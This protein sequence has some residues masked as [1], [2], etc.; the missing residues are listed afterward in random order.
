VV[1]VGD[2][3]AVDG[4]ADVSFQR[5][6]CF[7][8]GLGVGDLVVEVDAADAVLVAELGDG[9]RVDRRVQGAVPASRQTV[10]DPTTGGV[11]DRCGPGVR[12]EVITV[13]EPADVTDV[14]IT[15]AAIIG[16]TPNRSVSVVDDAFTAIAMRS[17][18]SFNWTS[19]GRCRR[20]TR[21]PARSGSVRPATT[22]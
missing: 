22:A 2:E 18:D 16:P 11:L 3:L 19:S 14:A 7:A 13:A 6:E 1:G 10:H 15:V 17:C 20:S 5:S 8:F 9:G 4:V 21:E 12:G